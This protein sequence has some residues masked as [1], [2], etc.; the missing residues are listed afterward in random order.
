MKYLLQISE[1]NQISDLVDD[2]REEE[3]ELMNG[4]S[5][6]NHL[7][8]NGSEVG[9]LFDGGSDYEGGDEDEVF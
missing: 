2:V 5:H 9:S 7:G 8:E 4:S 6:N 3:E 1:I